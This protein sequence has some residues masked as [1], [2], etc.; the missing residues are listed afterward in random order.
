MVATA[1]IPVPPQD[2][3]GMERRHQPHQLASRSALSAGG[4][5]IVGLKYAGASSTICRANSRD[6]E[7]FSAPSASIACCC[8][9]V[10]VAGTFSLEHPHHSPCPASSRRAW[11]RHRRCRC[12]AP[13]PAAIPPP[14]PASPNAR[15]HSAPAPRPPPPQTPSCPS[16][17][18]CFV[19]APSP[20]PTPANRHATRIIIRSRRVSLRSIT[21]VARES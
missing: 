19:S 5:C 10:A 16:A 12:S 9:G 4:C 7:S 15:T 18:P 13:P 14:W 3:H 1:Q 2:Q 21:S 6:G 8:S 17:S 20:A 11:C